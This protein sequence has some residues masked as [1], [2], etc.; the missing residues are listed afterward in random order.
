M[1]M[2]AGERLFDILNGQGN[3]GGRCGVI[4]HSQLPAAG[5]PHLWR[6]LSLDPVA[7]AHDL[8]AALR[9]MDHAGVDLIVVEAPPDDLTDGRRRP[10]ARAAAGSGGA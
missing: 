10:P 1:R 9:E 6:R 4:G 3:K 2:V 8:Y 5:M 7:Y